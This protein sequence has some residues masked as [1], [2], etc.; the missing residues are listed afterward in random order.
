M[1]EQHDANKLYT[2]E[3]VAECVAELIVRLHKEGG[4]PLELVFAAAHGQIVT[5]MAS[6]IGGERAAERCI[7]AAEHVRP[8]LSFSEAAL[9]T[10]K[11]QGHA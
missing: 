1:A 9:A 2:A 8:I 6:V 11:P 4:V 7:S 5:M 3:R 10:A